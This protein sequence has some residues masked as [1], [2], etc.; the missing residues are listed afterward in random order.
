MEFKD[1]L[2]DM[3]LRGG[4]DMHIRVGN[5][6]TLLVKD[7]QRCGLGWRQ[8]VANAVEHPLYD[9]GRGWVWDHG[10]DVFFV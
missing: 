4:S 9:A 2:E 1:L 5:G 10:Q 3:V 8:T 7:Q 6:R